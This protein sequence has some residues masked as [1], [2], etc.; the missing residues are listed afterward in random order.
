MSQKEKKSTYLFWTTVNYTLTENL[1]V[2]TFWRLICSDIVLQNRIAEG[3]KE[4]LKGKYLHK[5]PYFFSVKQTSVFKAK[6]LT[7][8][9]MYT[10][11]TLQ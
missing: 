5:C 6:T 9:C 1:E 4:L 2:F 10:A 3:K 8:Y 11:V 7:V